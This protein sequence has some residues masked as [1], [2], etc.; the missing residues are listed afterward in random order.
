M[1][2]LSGIILLLLELIELN[3]FRAQDVHKIWTLFYLLVLLLS[4]IYFTIR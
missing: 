1:D 2:D 3:V 4:A